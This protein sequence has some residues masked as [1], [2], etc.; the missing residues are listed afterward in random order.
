[1]EVKMMVAM[2][3]AMAIFTARSGA[4][5]RSP[6]MRVRK[7]TMT[8]PPPMPSNPAKKPVSRPKAPNS[9]IRV[10]SKNMCGRL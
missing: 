3:V 4:T 2:D 5:P 9:A 1:M 6:N 8:M 10:G 7:G